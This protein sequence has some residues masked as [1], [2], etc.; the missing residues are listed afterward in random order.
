MRCYH[1]TTRRR[2]LEI[3]CKGFGEEDVFTISERLH[4]VRLLSDWRL[5]TNP[6][7]RFKFVSIEPVGSD[8]ATVPEWLLKTIEAHN[9]SEAERERLAKV[10]EP[11]PIMPIHDPIGYSILEVTFAD[12]VLRDDY[13]YE[14][15]RSIRNRETGEI[16]T[17]E[18]FVWGGEWLTPLDLARR[19]YVR[20]LEQR[21][22]EDAIQ[23]LE[24]LR[25]HLNR[26]GA[27]AGRGRPGRRESRGEHPRLV[28]RRRHLRIGK[29]EAPPRDWHRRGHGPQPKDERRNPMAT[30][31][32][33]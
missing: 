10:W 17:T 32:L 4:G 14:E 11:E 23:A 21:V 29:G 7:L 24:S 30:P 19:G 27:L 33:P 26:R 2:A 12:D 3:L 20:L 1:A 8:Y 5:N 9:A 16:R 18:H 13:R 25:R 22:S 6:S 15:A 31:N 28:G